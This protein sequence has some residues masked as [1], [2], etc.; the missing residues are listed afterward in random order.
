MHTLKIKIGV[1]VDSCVFSGL[2][3]VQDADMK[4]E[5]ERLTTYE[6][7]PLYIMDTKEQSAAGFYFT[8]QGDVVCC[9]FCGVEEGHGRKVMSPSVYI[10]FGDRLAISSQ[11]VFWKH[12]NFIR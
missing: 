8:N 12:S 1:D 11:V 5:I 7:W 4:S 2:N 9:A 6:N 10:S 3:M